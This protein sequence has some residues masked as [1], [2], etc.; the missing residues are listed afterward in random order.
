VTKASR[1]EIVTVAS[2]SPPVVDPSSTKA[3][4]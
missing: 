2:A 4:S 1:L 3:S